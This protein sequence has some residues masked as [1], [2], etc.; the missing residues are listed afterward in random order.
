MFVRPGLS[1]TNY[2]DFI[3]KIRFEYTLHGVK[4]TYL[5]DAYTQKDDTWLPN[6]S[7]CR[8][9]E[10][11]FS[12]K[13]TEP[14]DIH[15]CIIVDPWYGKHCYQHTHRLDFS[16]ERCQAHQIEDFIERDPR[17]KKFMANFGKKFA[18]WFR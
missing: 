8:R 4:Q 11:N 2:E 17:T 9:D 14:I 16:N 7:C 12:L 15:V 5:M 3:H 10:I 18:R 6:V 13:V 1:N